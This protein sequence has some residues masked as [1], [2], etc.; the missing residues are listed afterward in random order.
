MITARAALKLGKP[1]WVVPGSYDNPL[2]AGSLQLLKEGAHVLTSCSS[3]LHY[4]QDLKQPRLKEKAYQVHQRLKDQEQIRI[5][6][7]THFSSLAFKIWN[8]SSNKP[9][10]IEDLSNKSHLT[11][12]EAS[13]GIIEL[14]LAGWLTIQ[15]GGRYIQAYGSP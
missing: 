9:Q 14:E 5:S 2:Y 12:P 11:M 7:P 8:A 10:T 13:L 15:P 4:F 3:W 6:L 1:V